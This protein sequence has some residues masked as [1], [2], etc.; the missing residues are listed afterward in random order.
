LIKLHSVRT[1]QT[2]LQNIEMAET[3]QRVRLGHCNENNW[4]RRL[5][6]RAA[7]NLLPRR[8]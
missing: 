5:G 4:D 2:V 6:G 8:P 3:S 7:V 1:S